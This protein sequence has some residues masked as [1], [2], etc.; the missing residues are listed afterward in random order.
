MD[1]RIEDLYILLAESSS[2][3]SKIII[4]Q[5]AELGITKFDVV[6]N[7]AEVLA[8]L[9]NN[10][11]D[12][13]MANMYL[14]DMS[15]TD[16]VHKLREQDKFEELVF[17]LVSTETSFE[18]LDPIK[19]AGATAVLPK[20]FSTKQLKQALYT[21]FEY[22][23]P[24]ELDIENVHSEN[25]H[26]L[27]VDDSRF[28]RNQIMRT[29]GKMGVERFMQASDGAEAIPIID[30][31]YFDLIITD[32]NMP[33]VSGQELIEYVRTKSHQP[34]VP[35]MMVTTEE[36]GSKL[37]AVERSGVSAI[38]DKPFEPRTVKAM[39]ESVMAA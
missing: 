6:E 3:Q 27:V 4:K 36:N 32:Y 9:E 28:A 8:F 34:T 38:C 12:L 16:L 24:D 10:T 25:M 21:T 18:R 23:E 39:I 5:F 1:Y 11:P 17:M 15:S 30:A 2:T 20:P 31:E 29:L 13:V 37:A 35:I 19:Q 7:G 33:K 26:V 22:L 14:P